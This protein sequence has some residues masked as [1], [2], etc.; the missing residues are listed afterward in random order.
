MQYFCRFKDR[1]F[2]TGKR[3]LA[4]ILYVWF[5]TTSI[6]AQNDIAI[7]EDELRNHVEYLASYGLE[8]RS[9]GGSGDYLAAAYIRNCFLQYGL[10]TMGEDGFQPFTVITGIRKGH[11]NSFTLDGHPATID[12][13]FMPMAISGNGSVS[14]HLIFLGYGFRIRTD[15]LVWD[16]Y[17]GLETRGKIGII[18][19]GAP[20]SDISV[21]KDPY[22]DHGTVRSKL[23]H[24]KDAGI[25]GVILVAGPSYDDK[26]ELVFG[27]T[28]ESSAGL[29]VVRATRSFINDHLRIAGKTIDKIEEDLNRLRKPMPAVLDV[30][31]EIQT[32]ILSQLSVTQ[33]VMAYI[34]A[35]DTGAQQQWIIV[36]AHYDHLGRGGTGTSSRAP[37][38]NEVHPGADDNASGVALMI[39]VAGNLSSK[40]NELK[41]SVLFVAFGAEE[42]GLVGSKYMIMNLPEPIIKTSIS[43]MLNFD[44]VGRP[45]NR[46]VHISGTGTAVEMDSLLSVWPGGNLNASKLPEGYGPSDH[47]S[48]YAENIPVLYFSTGPHLDYHTPGD[49]PDKLDYAFMKTLAEES[50]KLIITVANTD[51]ILS[52]SEAGPK[53]AVSDRRNLKVTLGIM[54]DALSDRNDG[55]QVEFVTP[56]KPAHLA[57]ILKGDRIVAINGMAVT[58]I[59]DYMAR[60]KT[61]EPGQTANVELVRE[62]RKIVVL[63]QF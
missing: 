11:L 3:L 46:K 52:F 30:S 41:R 7:T 16:D 22:E 14:G 50:E 62:G 43:A 33:N 8:G 37:G 18:L 60:M 34:P 47:A 20:E 24:A 9:P 15:S 42:M 39:E 53:P 29:P 40:R 13:D 27:T 44:M 25:E 32:G 63:V 49:T 2:M 12:A 31:A 59:Y 17:E 38:Q 54:P 55:L 19:L 21:E 48:F 56:G 45:E 10:R 51:H 5:A 4:G 35:S 58:N 36:G 61:L 1:P 6:S 23:I 28:K 26:D 57:G